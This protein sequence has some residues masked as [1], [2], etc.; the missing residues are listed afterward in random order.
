M[1]I[2]SLKHL[3]MRLSVNIPTVPDI[4]RHDSR[5]MRRG[6]AEQRTCSHIQFATGA[7]T[8]NASSVTANR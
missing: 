3:A 6:Q 4:L 8:F 2:A 5:R 7:Q 1:T